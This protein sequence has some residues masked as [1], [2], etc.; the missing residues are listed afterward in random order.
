[1]GYAG[2]IELRCE[3]PS[4]KT[5]IERYGERY[6]RVQAISGEDHAAKCEM[7]GGKFRNGK[8]EHKCEKCGKEVEPGGLCG[9]FVPYMCRECAAKLA[10]DE[11]TR[12]AV[13]R[14]CGLPYSQCCC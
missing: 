9:L 3:T 8:W 4:C 2:K 11:R 14:R 10:S 6:H 12:G 5:N 1:M 13:C 7:C